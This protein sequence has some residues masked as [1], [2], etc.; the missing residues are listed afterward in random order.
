[1]L[2]R[3][4]TTEMLIAVALATLI[5][6]GVFLALV[7]FA[8]NR[9]AGGHSISNTHSSLIALSGGISLGTLLLLGS[10]P[11]LAAP[12]IVVTALAVAGRWRARR[13]RQAGWLA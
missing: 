4:A 12:I 13:R 8:A 5:V 7:A 11:V 10:D 1:M 6:P 2:E 3:L 9:L